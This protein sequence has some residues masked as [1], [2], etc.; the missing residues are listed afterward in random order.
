MEQ[1]II[2]L[3]FDM[4]KFTPQQKEVLNGL[5]QVIEVADRIDGLKIG[6]SVSPTWKAL[7]DAISAQAVE[8][9]KLQDA[10]LN[11]VKAQE[12]LTKAETAQIVQMQQK[13]KLA[14][15]EIKTRQALN[16]ES[17][18]SAAASA[19]EAKMIDQLT[20]EYLQLNKAYNDAV[21]KY[22]N[23]F[24]VKGEDA[25][26]TKRQLQTVTEYRAILDKM[27]KNLNIHTRNVG[28]YSSAFNGLGMSIQQVGRELPTLAINFQMFALAISN[29]LPILADEIQRTKKEIAALQAEGKTAPTLFEQIGKSIFSWQTALTIGITLFTI[30]AKEI[31]DFVQGLFDADVALKKVAEQQTRF[32]EAL[33]QSAQAYEEVEGYRSKVKRT[34]LDD[35]QD[36]INLQTKLGRSEGDLLAMGKKRAEEAVKMYS[37]SKETLDATVADNSAQ[38]KHLESIADAISKINDELAKNP[39]AGKKSALEAQKKNMESEM[40]VIGLSF[41]QSSDIIKNYYESKNNL[42]QTDAAL[43]KYN[44]LQNTEILKD[45]LINDA[46]MQIAKNEVVLNSEASTEK[47]RLTAIKS[48]FEERKKIAKAEIEFARNQPGAYNIDANGKKTATAKTLAAEI[49]FKEDM[50]AINIEFTDKTY[51]TTEEYRKRDLAADSAMLKNKLSI[52]DEFAKNLLARETASIQDRLA[53]QEQL[54]KDQE[55]A[56]NDRYKLAKDKKGLTDKEIEAIE[57]EHQTNL[58]L[59]ATRATVSRIELI[60]R[61]TVEAIQRDGNIIEANNLDILAADYNA[62]AD[63]LERKKITLKQFNEQKSVIDRNYADKSLNDQLIAIDKTIEAEKAADKDI[64]A[65]MKQRESLVA[66]IAKN[67]ANLI[68]E[69]AKTEKEKEKEIFDKVK[70]LA[71]ATLDLIHQTVVAQYDIEIQRLQELQAAKAEYYAT[72]IDNIKNSSLAADEKARRTKV[73]EADAA[74]ARKK[75]DAEIREQNI[76]KAKADR[77]FQIFQIIGNTAIGISKALSELNPV[78]AAIIGAIGAVQIAKVLATP[79]PKYA[80][81]TDNHPGGPAIYGEAGAEI[82][83]EPGKNPYIVDQATLGLLP[84]GTKVTPMDQVND[85]MLSSM[86]RAQGRFM[87]RDSQ[88]DEWAIARWQ[89]GKLEKALNK[90]GKR[91]VRVNMSMKHSLDVN[92]SFGR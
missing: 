46:N 26:V 31:S 43:V 83:K 19:K 63:N 57:T 82:V 4:S 80:D 61:L 10:N 6:P 17:N 5:N 88:V 1:N 53:A 55:T 49:K 58:T 59:I 27:D 66:Q 23:L 3:G 76:K 33:L 52:Q 70:E 45:A 14:Q 11:Y 39:N 47:Q 28:N 40:K 35:M 18:A 8:I 56:E 12:A 2:E 75:Y 48:N 91:P 87:N 67:R 54:V 74:T 90:V 81:G 22:R 71:F 44:I 7:K 89:T 84:K 29:N 16:A 65:L 13:E 38:L 62:L 41:Q 72:E 69:T 20:N 24:L 60:R 73:L 36:Q 15:Q 30:Y 25:D 9:K 21:L 79:I 34:I 77:E 42:E 86:L 37:I 32:N 92:K 51:K 78:L 50:Q 85:L 68:A 64:T